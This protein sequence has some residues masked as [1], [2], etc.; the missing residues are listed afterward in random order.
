MF[1]YE[2]LIINI[3]SNIDIFSKGTVW[4]STYYDVLFALG[5][6]NYDNHIFA[7]TKKD[8]LQSSAKVMHTRVSRSLLKWLF[9][10]FFQ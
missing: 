5:N 2:W 1:W 9:R 4:F 7:D 6:I 3:L 10:F 8:A